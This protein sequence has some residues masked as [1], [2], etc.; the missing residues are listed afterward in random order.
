MSGNNVAGAVRR[1]DRSLLTW[2]Y[3]EGAVC[4]TCGRASGGGILCARCRKGLDDCALPQDDTAV[5]RYE[6]EAGELVRLLKERAVAPAAGA[7]ALGMAKK[8]AD[9]G[10]PEDAVLTS[11][12]MPETRRRQ[13]G[14]DHGWELALAL[15]AITGLK[16]RPLMRRKA[17][18]ARTQRGL[19]Q[20]ERRLNVR[21]AFVALAPVPA[22]VILTDDVL[23][24]GATT[25]E[26]A[27]CLQEAGCERVILI[28]ACRAGLNLD[29]AQSAEAT[30][31]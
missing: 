12:P 14:I 15:S 6:N 20:E 4:L 17:R 11:V 16:A 24:T 19:G 31:A 25:G 18:N 8:L 9:M 1:A 3:P 21:D 5:W 13:R 2:A 7:L 26:C 22:T 10:F 28:T 29:N 30:D 23:T 27:R